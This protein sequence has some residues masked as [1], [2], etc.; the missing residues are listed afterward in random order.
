M[1]ILGPPG[2]KGAEGETVYGPPG[3]SGNDGEEGIP[4]EPGE[5]G[6][7]GLPGP[8][9]YP[10]IGLPIVGPP[11]EYGQRGYPG[12]FA[13]EVKNFTFIVLIHHIG[14]LERLVGKLVKYGLNP[15]CN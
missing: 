1:G 7:M 4:G 2:E 3:T 15:N 12:N 5:R 13:F 14:T 9:G 10:G 6:D 11:G 8:K